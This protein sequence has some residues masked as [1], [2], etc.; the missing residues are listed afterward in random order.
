MTLN[1]GDSIYVILIELVFNLINSLINTSTKSMKIDF[2]WFFW[3]SRPVLYMP[4][5]P[6]KLLDASIDVPIPKNAS[7]SLGT[8]HGGEW[9]YPNVPKRFHSYI[10]IYIY[11]QNEYKSDLP[12]R[13]A[14]RLQEFR[15]LMLISAPARHNEYNCQY[16][17]KYIYIHIYRYM[18][19]YIY[20]WMYT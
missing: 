4:A 3:H 19:L 15:G 14:L 8:Y 6:N 16:L 20:I 12:I 7:K 2:S 11:I 18:C 10:Y 5:V 13:A 1:L 17:N 9:G